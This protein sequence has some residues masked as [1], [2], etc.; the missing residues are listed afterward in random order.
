MA[1]YGLEVR[2]NSDIVMIDSLFKNHSYLESGSVSAQQYINSV[3]ITPVQLTPYAFIKA[4]TDYAYIYAVEQNVDTGYYDKISIT[5]NSAQTVNWILYQEGHTKAVPDYGLTVY[6]LDATNNI[7]FH[8]AEDGYVNVI[9]NRI[10]GN[11]NVSVV[12]ADNNYFAVLGGTEKYQ[13]SYSNG[14]YTE[15][16]YATG[17]KYVDS[18]TINVNA[19]VYYLYSFPIAGGGITGSGSQVSSGQLIEM[20]PPITL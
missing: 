2:N 5:S 3:D 19:F 10:I 1:D 17:I 15:Q 12:D 6:N 11:G 4:P 14:Y 13:Y 9:N 16:R 7:V 20:S 18:T 8:S